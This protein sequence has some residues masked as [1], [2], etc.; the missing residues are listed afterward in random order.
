MNARELAEQI[1]K[2]ANGNGGGT[3]FQECLSLVK[4]VLSVP[5]VR[6]DKIVIYHEMDTS[7]DTSHLGEYTNKPG[8]PEKT[9]DRC[10]ISTT[11]EAQRITREHE[12]EYFVAAM[13]GK[14]TGNPES[15]MQDYRRMEALNRGEWYFL[16]IYAH[17]V[18]SY[19]I[20]QGCRRMESMR[21]G[22]LW[23]IESDYPVDEIA[24]V[25][26]DELADL[27]RHLETFGVDCSNFD[28]LAAK[29]ERRE[30]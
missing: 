9:I 12:Y 24:S 25:E 26:R 29:A 22:G 17:A 28:E 20:G 1:D 14:E 2:N 27:R 30:K 5:K 10:A 16:G 15:V 3:N 8:D 18:V 11:R 6:I 13:S 19:D 4:E 7:P 21:S 23:G